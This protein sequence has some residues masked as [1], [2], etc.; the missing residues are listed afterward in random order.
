M[1]RTPRQR[2]DFESEVARNDSTIRPPPRVNG[3]DLELED[4]AATTVLPL[5][6][7]EP[8]KDLAERLQSV[9]TDGVGLSRSVGAT[10]R[11]QWT[12]FWRSLGVA[13]VLGALL[14]V[15]PLR[16]FHLRP[17]T[18]PHPAPAA[19]AA[20]RVTTLPPVSPAPATTPPSPVGEA[21]PSARP[22]V[23]KPPID[24]TSLPKATPSNAPI[25]VVPRRVARP[26]ARAAPV[27]VAAD[28]RP[29]VDEKADNPY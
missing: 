8:P 2:S 13:V 24:V 20:A 4:D 7:P 5:R 1:A 10:A 17:A 18:L 16:G 11:P 22:P 9:R 14:R 23:T 21:A 12:W 6:W 29:R 25:R 28:A 3:Q 27:D 26:T 15:V 19:A